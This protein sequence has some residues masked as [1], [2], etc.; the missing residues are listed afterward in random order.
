MKNELFNSFVNGF[1]DSFRL[2]AYLFIGV[3]AIISS[4][5]NYSLDQPS[6]QKANHSRG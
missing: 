4:F 2:A 3:A 1:K 6:H 5:S